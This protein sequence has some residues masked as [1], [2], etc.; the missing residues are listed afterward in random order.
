MKDVETPIRQMTVRTRQLKGVHG[1]MKKVK[2][3]TLK[4][5]ARRVKVCDAVDVDVTMQ[6][7][8]DVVPKEPLVRRTAERELLK[9]FATQ[10]ASSNAETCAVRSRTGR[11]PAVALPALDQVL[12]MWCRCRTEA[13]G[14][15]GNASATSSAVGLQRSS[16]V[17]AGVAV[18]CARASGRMATCCMGVAI[19][20]AGEAEEH[21]AGAFSQRRIQE[22][23]K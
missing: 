6:V 7:R 2:R 18:G 12:Q 21:A 20:G 10:T 3:G 13:F 9:F 8:V 16:T 22:Q 19:C 11:T 5:A 23:R 17:G 4:K 14:M 15:V 1:N